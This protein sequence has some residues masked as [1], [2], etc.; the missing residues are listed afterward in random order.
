MDQSIIAAFKC[1][2]R[3]LIV[4]DMLYQIEEKDKHEQI[5]NKA[6]NFIHFGGVA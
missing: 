4:L 6:I 1:Y 5:K 2:Y 3:K